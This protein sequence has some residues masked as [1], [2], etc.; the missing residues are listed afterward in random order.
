MAALP[1]L[2]FALIMGLTWNTL[3]R[4]TEVF[5][6]SGLVEMGMSAEAFS[7]ETDT[8]ATAPGISEPPVEDEIAPGIEEPPTRAARAGR[9]R[10]ARGTACAGRT[11]FAGRTAGA[12]RARDRRRGNRQLREREPAPAAFWKTVGIGV[13]MLGSAICCSPSRGWKCSTCCS[14]PSFRSR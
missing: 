1:A 10:S 9:T 6:T 12:G 8:E 4:P 5:D 2:V 13:V 7:S 11:R 14:R 3:T